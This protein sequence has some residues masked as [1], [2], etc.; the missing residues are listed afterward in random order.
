METPS[1]IGKHLRACDTETPTI[2]K[3]M[4]LGE[5]PEGKIVLWKHWEFE[6]VKKIMIGGLPV[7]MV[8]RDTMHDEPYTLDHTTM[9]V[10]VLV[11][12]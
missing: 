12:D 1:R 11:E 5:V 4:L 10:K 3:E 6:V 2:G 7:K 9:V 8:I